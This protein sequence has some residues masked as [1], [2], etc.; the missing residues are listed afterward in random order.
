M[1]KQDR[2]HRKQNQHI[3]GFHLQL[4]RRFLA[5]VLPLELNSDLHLREAHDLNAANS[6]IPSQKDK[7]LKNFALFKPCATEKLKST[8]TSPKKAEN[9]K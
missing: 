6:Q 9:T 2:K 8:K 7:K 4:C 1:R 5:E 3:L